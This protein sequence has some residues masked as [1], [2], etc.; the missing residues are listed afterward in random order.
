MLT[1]N[2]VNLSGISFPLIEVSSNPLNG[3]LSSIASGIFLLLGLFFSF[4][5]AQKQSLKDR[6]Q[7][8]SPEKK[9]QSLL[10]QLKELRIDK[11]L[12][13][14]S[15]EIYRILSGLF[16]HLKKLNAPSPEIPVINQVHIDLN[17]L[18]GKVYKMTNEECIRTQNAIAEFQGILKENTLFDQS[19]VF[20]DRLGTLSQTVIDQQSELSE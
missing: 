13:K 18:M 15:Q 17:T 2:P 9:E 7:A 11:S 1:V 10:S 16:S 8:E 14:Q 6:V 20:Q 12:T 4:T 3:V 19:K 5:G